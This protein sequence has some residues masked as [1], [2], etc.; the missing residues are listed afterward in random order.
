MKKIIE[1]LDYGGD[2]IRFNTD[3][4][5]TKNHKDNVGVLT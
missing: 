5:V 2:D 1:V 4:D 3:L